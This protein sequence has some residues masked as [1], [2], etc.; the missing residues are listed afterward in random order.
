MGAHRTRGPLRLEHVLYFSWEQMSRA[1]DDA[2]AH[3]TRGGETAVA[4]SG[5]SLV[6]GSDGGEDQAT[7]Q[8]CDGRLFPASGV[9]VR[10]VHGAGHLL[11]G[12]VEDV[13]KA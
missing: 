1:M 10:V 12:D 8:G 13:L 4:T 9:R 2:D 7:T 5:R 6:L 3:T 11:P